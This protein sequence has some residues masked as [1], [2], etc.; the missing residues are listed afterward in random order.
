MAGIVPATHV[1]LHDARIPNTA[2]R[3]CSFVTH[4]KKRSLRAGRFIPAHSSAFIF[5]AVLSGMRRSHETSC[6]RDRMW[7]LLSRLVTAIPGRL[8]SPSV[9]TDEGL[10]SMAGRGADERGRKIKSG[11]PA[12][13]ARKHGPEAQSRRR[14]SAARRVRRSQGART[15]R[16]R[17]IFAA[18]LGAPLPHFDEGAK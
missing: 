11:L 5:A 6:E 3:C 2:T 7:R 1:I 9:P 14:W 15:P 17:G 16:K 10:P 12:V 13:R 4:T 18:P 8:G